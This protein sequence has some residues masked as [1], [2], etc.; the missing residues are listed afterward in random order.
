MYTEHWFTSCISLYTDYDNHHEHSLL[1]L[2]HILLKKLFNHVAVIKHCS[3]SKA[4]RKSWSLYGFMVMMICSMS[5]KVPQWESLICR[6]WE[7]VL[8]SGDW[9]VADNTRYIHMSKEICIRSYQEI[10]HDGV[11]TSPYPWVHWCKINKDEDDTAL[12]QKYYK[13]LVGNLIDISY[14]Y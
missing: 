1:E 2:Q 5:L 11:Q 7:N 3:L 6:T 4:R 9:S 13:Q 12:N 14:V 10:W 8:F